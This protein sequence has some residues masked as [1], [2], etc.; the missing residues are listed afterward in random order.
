MISGLYAW[1]RSPFTWAAAVLIAVASAV[2]LW[3]SPPRGDVAGPP[4]EIGTAKVGG[5]C[6]TIV[7]GFDGSVGALA[8]GSIDGQL[9][10]VDA[11]DVDRSQCQPR[12]PS[13]EHD[14]GPADHGRWTPGG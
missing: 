7:T 4:A 1:T 2:S 6:A 13:G 10:K 9:K 8:P 3:V 5:Y 11:K 12:K 14:Q